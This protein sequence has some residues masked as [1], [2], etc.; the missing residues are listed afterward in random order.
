MS[1]HMICSTPNQKHKMKIII[2]RIIL[3]SI[4]MATLAA[5]YIIIRESFNS[6]ASSSR[7]GGVAINDQKINKWQQQYQH[8]RH[9]TQILHRNEQEKMQ[10]YKDKWR[11]RQF[12]YLQQSPNSIIEAPLN[13][14]AGDQQQIDKV[15]RIKSEIEQQSAIYATIQRSLQEKYHIQWQLDQVKL[16]QKKSKLFFPIH[17]TSKTTS[18]SEQ[19]PQINNNI[20]THNNNHNHNRK[21]E[22]AFDNAYNTN[23]PGSTYGTNMFC[24][25]SWA[26]AS[27]SCESR[28]NCPSG[29]SSECIMPGHECWA[30]TECDTRYG[31]GEQ[32]GE[33]HN[34]V[35]G[36]NLEASGVGAVE[37]GGYVDLSKPSVDKT[38]HYFCGKGY[39][40][41]ITHCATHCP[42][43]SLNDCPSGE[44]CFFNTPCDARMMTRVPSPPSPTYSPTTPAPVKHGD[45]L[46]KYAC[47]YDW[48]DAQTR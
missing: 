30:F 23:R 29:Q 40:D 28:Q 37:S 42:S 33:F 4:A 12:R 24:G 3:F 47:G 20:H 5:S 16:Q 7:R 48:D 6:L 2:R 9:F 34:V 10:I 13:Y 18:Y 44:I 35:G 36:S 19:Y 46:N 11:D 41:A 27:T 22:D 31:H 8:Q 21:L 43:G 25:M 38:D 39:D 15:E 45:K 32:F 1:D 14:I 26:D 17:T